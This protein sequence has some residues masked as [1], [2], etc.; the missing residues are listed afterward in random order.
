MMG[1]PLSCVDSADQAG[2]ENEK[3]LTERRRHERENQQL[4]AQLARYTRPLVGFAP[5]AGGSK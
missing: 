2:I 4:L 1:S 3:L 5:A